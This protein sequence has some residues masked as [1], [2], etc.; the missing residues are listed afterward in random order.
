M[1]V[2]IFYIARFVFSQNK[3]QLF[4]LSEYNREYR[5]IKKLNPPILFIYCRLYT[6]KPK[7]HKKVYSMP[8]LAP[9]VVNRDNAA[10]S[11]LIIYL[12]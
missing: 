1:Q 9:V 11:L 5:D 4:R 12:N 3:Q 10:C 7:N 2:C 8:F 6:A